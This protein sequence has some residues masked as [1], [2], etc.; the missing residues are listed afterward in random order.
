MTDDMWVALIWGGAALIA[1]GGFG[2]ALWKGN[3]DVLPDE[4]SEQ[5]L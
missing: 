2:Y 1:I 5:D 3:D 4:K